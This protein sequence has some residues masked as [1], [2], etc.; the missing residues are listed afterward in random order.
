MFDIFANK[1]KKGNNKTK[2]IMCPRSLSFISLT[3]KL[4]KMFQ[5]FEFA[6]FIFL[7]MKYVLIAIIVTLAVVAARPETYTSRFDNVDV[8]RIL[9]TKRLFDS[10]F[11][12]LMD[13][14]KCTPDGKELKKLLP[15]A[16]RT[17]CEKCT[18]KQRDGTDR[19][20]R[21]IVKNKP[22]EWNLVSGRE[23]ICNN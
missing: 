2:A 17:N 16:L 5:V 21:F 11:K 13:Q 7:Q 3:K 1:K 15:D 18:E 12:C 14:G 8:D 4:P 6:I 22:E 23:L 20:L 9:N 19:V 10:Y